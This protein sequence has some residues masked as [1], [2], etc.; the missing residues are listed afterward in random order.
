MKILQVNG[1]LHDK[2]QQGMNLMTKDIEYVIT[3]NNSRFHEE[4]DFVLVPSF[5][6]PKEQFPNTKVIIYGPHIFPYE[7]PWSI[8][9]YVNDN[10]YF[11]TLSSWVSVVT[12]EIC[13]LSK[14]I[15]TINLPFGVDV[16]TFKPVENKIYEYDCF[17]YF[18]NREIEC[19]EYVQDICNKLGLKYVVIKYG[20]YNQEYYKHVLNTSKFG[21]WVGSHESQGFAVQ[22]ALSQNVPLLVW[23][24]ESLYDEVNNGE[25]PWQKYKGKCV[26]K[27]TTVG[28]WDDSCGII[29]DKDKLE[30]NINKML[31]TYQNYNPRQFIVETLSP[32]I[33][34]ERWI[35]L[36]K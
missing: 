28:Y 2:N 35:K 33:C 32:E 31:E 15:K 9:N 23:D 20:S 7:E 8:I 29:T 11:N 16:E 22:E 3:T 18:K 17:I 14:N 21:I 30:T 1:W 12:E 4:W 25:R 26:L 27:A 24:V 34:M 5:F 10:V 13:Q 6:I 19:F 36:L